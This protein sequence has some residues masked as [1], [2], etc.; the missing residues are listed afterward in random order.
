[1]LSRSAAKEFKELLKVRWLS[2]AKHS[3]REMF[4]NNIDNNLTESHFC[5]FKILLCFK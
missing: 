5:I 4:L 1:M 2:I 3:G